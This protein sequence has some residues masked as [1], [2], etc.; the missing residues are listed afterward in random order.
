[1]NRETSWS[2]PNGLASRSSSDAEFRNDLVDLIP[3]LRAFSRSLCGNR[4]LA[5][6]MAQDALVKAWQARAS[7]AMG[8]NLKAWLFTI[9]RN[10]FYSD[11]RRRWRERPLSDEIA[12]RSLT[13]GGE[14][15]WAVAFSDMVR[16][17]QR[18]P[19]EQ[20]EALVLVAASG[21]PYDRAASICD[22]A[23]G[24]IKSRVARARKALAAAMSDPSPITHAKRVAGSEAA[25]KTIAD[26]DRTARSKSA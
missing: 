17:L 13:T 4:D 14:Q 3:H 2:K 9:L 18:L 26:I 7:F 5:E 11:R 19:D 6:D 15:G 21:L 1:M 24:T 16:A 10:Q 22:C 25:W 20:R 8:T 23:V 12:E